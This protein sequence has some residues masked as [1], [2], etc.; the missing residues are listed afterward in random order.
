MQL[1][2]IEK[3]QRSEESPSVGGA[4]ASKVLQEYRSELKGAVVVAS[5]VFH[6][7]G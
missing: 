1:I 5:G 4:E 3:T 2:P 6:A 7:P